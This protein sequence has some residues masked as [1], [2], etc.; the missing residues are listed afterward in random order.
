MSAE[1]YRSPQFVSAV[2]YNGN[3]RVMEAIEIDLEKNE[4]NP[5]KLASKMFDR[6]NKRIRKRYTSSFSSFRQSM[7]TIDE[8]EKKEK[9]S[10]LLKMK[11][12]LKKLGDEKKKGEHVNTILHLS[13]DGEDLLSPNKVDSQNGMEMIMTEYEM[14]EE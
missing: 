9:K 14:M 12:T 6:V 3:K 2:E 11:S 10:D 1:G 13:S 8:E 5:E 7:N 4:K